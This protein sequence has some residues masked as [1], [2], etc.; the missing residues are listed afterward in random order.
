MKKHL[1]LACLVSLLTPLAAEN[2]TICQL[3]EKLLNH[4]NDFKPLMA[5][6]DPSLPIRQL[7]TI[8]L[9]G[10]VS[11]RFNV[12][13]DVTFEAEL[14]RYPSQMEA[15][16]AQ[17]KWAKALMECYPGMKF[18]FRR[19]IILD[20][21]FGY[22]YPILWNE[23]TIRVFTAAFVIKNITSEYELVFECKQARE[24]T[25]TKPAIVAFTDYT[26][27]TVERDDSPF[28][29]ALQE[30]LYQA[31]VAFEEIKGN[32]EDDHIVGRYPATL[33]LPGYDNCYVDTEDNYSYVVSIC[34]DVDKETLQ[35]KL[36][37]VG[38]QIVAALGKD[39]AYRLSKDGS[40]V[41]YVRGKDPDET[42]AT[43][44]YTVHNGLYSAAFIVW[45]RD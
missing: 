38:Q 6:K 19:E 32:D 3:F 13:N 18:G 23:T 43:L 31:T 2:V 10:A 21:T 17:N 33:K 37:P 11:S 1:L 36:A 4:A 41:Y 7:S 30:V 45:G 42:V 14:G 15:I 8:Q 9:E 26:M 34:K 25:L 35:A 28:T 27:L 24:E 40:T 20:H 39:Y 29:E 5:G 16:K 44:S 22:T 12:L